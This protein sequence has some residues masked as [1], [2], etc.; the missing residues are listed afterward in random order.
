MSKSK[1]L[2]A[3]VVATAVVAFPSGAVANVDTAVKQA[4]SHTI[5]ADRALDR[6][7]TLFAAG[8]DADAGRALKVSRRE[9]GRATAA[10][11]RA[12]RRARKSSERAKAARAVGRVA[13]QQD[14]NIET[15]V[16][17]LDEAEGR[18]EKQVAAA[19]LADTRG[20]D[21]AIAILAKLAE[22]GVSSKSGAGIARAV[23]ALSQGRDDEVDVAAEA[24]ASDDVS[25]RSKATL[26]DAVEENLDGQVKAGARI[27]KLVGSAKVPDAAKSGL[28]RAYD[29]V[30]R[31]QDSSSQA[32]D[33]ACEHMPAAVCERVR[34]VVAGARG[35][36]QEMRD[37]HP[38]GPPNGTPGGQPTGTP[39]GPPSGTPAP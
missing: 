5:K 30:I 14:E 10:A 28:Q 4:G 39:A 36:A 3:A 6:A 23:T 17:L 21:K 34:G 24:L 9:I 16:G 1:L 32:L 19:A 26:A 31:E 37:N 7:A 18:T 35:N 27:A 13:D 25:E 22:R 38:S 8:R 11:K 2:P 20:R 15:L 33:R 29:A 12:E